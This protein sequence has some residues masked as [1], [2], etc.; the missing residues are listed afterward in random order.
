[1]LRSLRSRGP[2]KI[3]EYGA[4][5]PLNI[6]KWRMFRVQRSASY[7]CAVAAMTC[8]G[9]D[10]HSAVIVIW[11]FSSPFHDARVECKGGDKVA[12]GG[13]RNQAGR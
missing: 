1:M 2:D 12:L 10:H 3:D 8:L 5:R 7:W 11:K 4:A 6:G 13:L 9:L